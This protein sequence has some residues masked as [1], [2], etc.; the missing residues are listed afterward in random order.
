MNT[1]SIITLTE[2]N[3]RRAI[4]DYTAH[5]YQTE[6]IEGSSKKRPA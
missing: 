1:N 6:G 4:A 5:T 3:I 2:E